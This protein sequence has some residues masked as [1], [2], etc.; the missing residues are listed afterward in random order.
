MSCLAVGCAVMDAASLPV[1]LKP[2]AVPN[3]L[4]PTF[5]IIAG[6]FLAPFLLGLPLI[7]LGLSQLRRP[8]GTRTYGFLLPPLF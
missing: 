4:R 7:L 8:D 3:N 6:C 1:R 2:E 5:L